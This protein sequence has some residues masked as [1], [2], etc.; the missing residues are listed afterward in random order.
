MVKIVKRRSLGVQP[1][2]DIGVEKDHNFILANGLVASNC[3]NKSH[4]TAYAYVTYQTAYLKAN[5]PVEYM[6]ALLTASSDNQ[7]KVEKYRENCLKMGIDVKPPDINLSQKEFTPQGDNILFGFSAVKNLGESAIDNILEVR[8]EAGGKF[9]NF[10]D[11][12]SRVNLKTVNKR[13]LETLIYAGAF[14]CIHSNRRQLLEG[15]DLMVSWV[16]KRLKEKETGQL[17]IFEQM[18]GNSTNTAT[19]TTTEISYESAPQL[20][21]VDDFSPQEKLKSEKEHLG[22]YVSEH[23]LKPLKTKISIL[24]PINLS[25]LSSQKSRHKICT[26][27]MLNTIK[28]HVDKNGNN[29]AFLTLEDISGQADGVIFA[30]SYEQIKDNLVEDTPLIIWGRADN[31][32]EKSQI[33]VN[34]MS[35]IAETKLV[36]IRLSP[37]NASNP[38]IQG[39]IKGILQEQSGDK[40]QAVIPTF[41]VIEGA[42]ERII[43]RLGDAYWVQ[44]AYNTLEALTNASF[45]AY[46]QGFDTDS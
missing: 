21:R 34:Y 6:S 32:N 26:L 42:R 39:K 9:A 37:E 46:L 31:K 10:A 19:E 5:Y 22:F 43:V 40:N 38:S 3:F 4:S 24:S 11:F 44:D 13:A 2:Y 15:L 45:D 20:P 8:E 7:D 16:Q 30:S 23:P 33:I 36:F 18:M 1:V 27:A 14:D 12:I 29:M 41:V 35:K 28:S 17:N 25:E